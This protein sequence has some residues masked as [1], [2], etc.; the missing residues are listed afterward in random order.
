MFYH[1]CRYLYSFRGIHSNNDYNIL[2]TVVTQS[3]TLFFANQHDLNV[4]ISDVKNVYSVILWNMM[5]IVFIT[6]LM[7]K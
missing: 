2:I 6:T 7:L 5:T 4:C 1:K 3:F